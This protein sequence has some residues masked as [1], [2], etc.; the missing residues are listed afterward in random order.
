MAANRREDSCSLIGLSHSSIYSRHER[1]IAD[2]RTVINYNILSTMAAYMSRRIVNT[3]TCTR[4]IRYTST[5]TYN[6]LCTYL[7]KVCIFVYRCFGFHYSYY[8]RVRILLIIAHLFA[9][10]I[11]RKNNL[12]FL[13][14]TLQMKRRIIVYKQVSKQV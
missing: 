1:V 12:I 6:I 3:R 2:R 8:I 4:T 14:R 11:R 9:D 13:V 10:N 7:S 5:S